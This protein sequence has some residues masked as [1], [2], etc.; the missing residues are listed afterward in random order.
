M[1]ALESEQHKNDPVVS[2]HIMRMIDTDIL[3]Y[4]KTFRAILMKLRMNQNGEAITQTSEEHSEDEIYRCNRSHATFD[5]Q[6]LYKEEE[7]Q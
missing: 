5:D 7:E 2:Q 1:S 4:E 3:W 6:R